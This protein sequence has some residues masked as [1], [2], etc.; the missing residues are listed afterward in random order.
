MPCF[1]Y[2]HQ[3]PGLTA[4]SPFSSQS[5]QRVADPYKRRP[6]LF[7][8]SLDMSDAVCMYSIKQKVVTVSLRKSFFGWNDILMWLDAIQ[9]NVVM[10]NVEKNL[11][12][13]YVLRSNSKRA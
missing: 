8:R 7:V 4:S 5:R 3:Y 2:T 13:I 9:N 10:K 12:R 1:R 6:M 11:H